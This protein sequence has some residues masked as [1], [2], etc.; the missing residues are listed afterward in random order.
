MRRLPEKIWNVLTRLFNHDAL[1]FLF[2][3]AVAGIFWLLQTMNDSFDVEVMVPLHLDSIPENVMITT[4]PP[5]EVAATI[6]DRGSTLVRYWRH[7]ELKPIS[8]NFGKYD[9]GSVTARV[10]IPQS[11]IQRAI[12]EMLDGTSHVQSVRPDT[13][14]FYYNRGLHYRL[15]VRVCGT[16]TTSPQSYLMGIETTPD[17]VDVYAP[18]AILDTMQAAY[19]KAVSL[20]DLTS[21]VTTRTQLVGIKGVRYEPREVEL[22]A[23]VDFY[24]EKTVEVPIIGLNFPADKA[25]RTFPAKAKVTFRIGSAQFQQVNSE[26]FVL[27]ATYEELLQNVPTKY[28]LHLKSLPRGV[29]N[30]R[31]SPQDVDYLIETVSQRDDDEKEERE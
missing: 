26:N 27:A 10:Q 8:L 3:L 16:V 12:E 24:T 7:R 15:P 9:N 30:V 17:S 1:T 23:K 2:F 21:S 20:Q 28:H 19:T 5:S 11:T 31:I 13:I 6:R 18:T 14:E 4:E 22:K 29:S 25:L